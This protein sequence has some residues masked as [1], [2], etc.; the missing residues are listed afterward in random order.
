METLGFSSPWTLAVVVLG[1]GF[2]LGWLITG[3]PPRSKLGKMTAKAEDLDAKLKE[4]NTTLAAS[5]A[6]VEELQKEAAAAHAHEQELQTGLDAARSDLEQVSAQAEMRRQVLAARD[7]ELSTRDAELS[8][9]DAELSARD[10]ELAKRDAELAKREAELADLKM[11]ESALRGTTE[12]SYA[13]FNL[14]VQE[15][16][17]EV[18]RLSEENQNLKINLEG[19][20]KD[21]AKS[22]AQVETVAQAIANK[23][24]ALTEAYARAV[25]LERETTDEQGQLLSLQAEIDTLKRNLAT[26]TASTEEANR[27]L[28]NAR[29]EVAGELAALTSTMLRIKDEQLAQANATI[30]A[31]QAQMAAMSDG[32]VPS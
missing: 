30:T 4:T 12:Q 26:A 19:T 23:D 7:A 18:S 11:Q 1:I 25:R 21:L 24:A 10:A 22:R 29:G 9:R 6:H 27:R 31:L 16:A 20:A 5:Q 32:S 8:T 3:L 2:V 15:L 13:A 17:A 14:Q 28:E